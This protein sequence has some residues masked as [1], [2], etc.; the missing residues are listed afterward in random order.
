MVLM[1][2]NNYTRVIC[3]WSHLKCRK[4]CCECTILL[5]GDFFL[6]ENEVR[7]MQETHQ[8]VKTGLSGNTNQDEHGPIWTVWGTNKSQLLLQR[9]LS[10]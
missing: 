4:L 3:V 1:E 2:I 10:A 8:R 7:K 9:L 5:C 6:C